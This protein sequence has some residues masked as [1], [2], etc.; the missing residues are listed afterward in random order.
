MGELHVGQSASFTKTISESDVYLFAGITGDLN[1]LHVDEIYARETRFGR[2]IVHGMLV[3]SLIS[4]VQAMQLPGPGNIYIG[5]TLRFL[6]P[7]FLG[8]TITATVEVIEVDPDRNR[9]RLRTECS[10]HD[11]VVVISGESE[12]APHRGEAT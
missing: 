8:D 1:G 2:R 3:A 12:V 11:R 5:Q 4:S 7:V 10:N 9:V 6:A